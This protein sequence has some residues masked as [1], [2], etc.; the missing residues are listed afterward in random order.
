VRDDPVFP[1][2]SEEET[3]AVLRAA[4]YRMILDLFV[5]AMVIG[6]PLEEATLVMLLPAVSYR[7]H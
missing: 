5:P 7:V 6:E 4:M 3:T 2:I 1:L